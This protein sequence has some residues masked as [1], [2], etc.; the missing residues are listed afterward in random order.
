MNDVLTADGP[1]EV[2]A[3]APHPL[4]RR[5]ARLYRAD[6]AAIALPTLVFAIMGWHRRWITDDGLIFTRTARQIL[7]GNGPVYNQGERVETATSTLWQW[8]LALLGAI[9]PL[10]LAR[11]AVYTGLFLS[12][13]GLVVALDGTRRLFR[14]LAVTRPLVPVGALVFIAVPSVWDFA[15][16]G[17]ETGLMLAWIGTSWSLLVRT[18]LR[19]VGAE[20]LGRTLSTAVFFGLGPLVRP[21]LGATAVVLAVAQLLLIRPGLPRALATLG[22]AG[23]LPLGYEIFRMGYYGLVVPMPALTKEASHSV[24]GRGWD[25]L[26]DYLEPYRLWVPMVLVLVVVGLVLDR[27]RPADRRTWILVATPSVAAFG[28][29]LYVLKVGGDFMHGRMWL[30]VLLLVLLPL[31]L[32]PPVRLVLPAV[33]LIAVWALVC[34]VFLRTGI[35]TTP[36]SQPGQNQV[37]NERDVYAGWTG[38]KNPTTAGAHV[39]TLP[40]VEKGFRDARDSGRRVLLVDPGYPMFPRDLP[41]L[42]LRA[43]L[44]DSGG[45]IIGRLGVGGAI[46]PLDG[47]VVDV[48]GLANTVGAHIEQTAN[49]AAGHEKVLPAAWNIALYVDPGGYPLVPATTATQEQIRAARAALGCGDLRELL[50]SVSAP[51]TPSRFWDNLTGAYPRTSLR[52]PSDPV[53][54]ERKFC[55]R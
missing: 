24:W 4:R 13:A 9:S 18:W 45:L 51:M 43:D 10:D 42:P 41:P 21:D 49:A 50:E 1:T 30:P 54:A 52:I 46:T 16:A 32:A 12:V 3:P 15:T 48:L 40:S 55:E 19:P 33:A 2:A 34:G 38:T 14:G 20:H 47:I 28:Q 35:V 36:S 17:M 37:W 27:R 53:A 11:T 39:G 25:Y 5:L 22:C 44:L 29:S 6:V 23:L 7:A 31:L 8:L 26:I